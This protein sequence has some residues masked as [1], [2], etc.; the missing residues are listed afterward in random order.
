L[1]NKLKLVFKSV[2][3]FVSPAE[4]TSLSFLQL[5]DSIL[6]DM[7]NIYAFILCF[8]T[9]IGLNPSD[10]IE[11]TG[12]NTVAVETSNGKL[13]GKRSGD[14]ISFLG[15]P[16]AEPP[17]GKYR[18]R[19][20][21]PKKA[22]YPAE[23]KAFNYSAECLQSALYAGPS[24]R[25]D[26]DC[27]YLNVWLPAKPRNVEPLP[28]LVWIYGGAFLHGSA[29]RPEYAGHKLASKGSVIVVSLNYRVG[30]LGFLVS[31]RDSLFGN[32]GLHD[33][34]LALQWIV[35]NIHLFGGDPN[36]ITVFGESAGAMSI[37]L[38][39]FDQ[40]YNF[41]SQGLAQKSKP[42][43]HGVILQSNP[44]GYKYRSLAVANFIGNA[45]KELLDCED[46]R[47]LHAESADELIHVQDT[48][49]AVP[50]S[51]GDFFT[52]G[53][54]VTD[55]LYYREVRL[56]HGPSSNITVRQP[57]ETMN[58]LRK[59]N[60]PILM[61]TNSHEGIVFVYTA[62]PRRMIK[63]L[64]QAVVWSFFRESAI[65][66]LRM[67]API[68]RRIDK[69]LYP[70]YRLVLSQII[71]DYLFRCPNLLFSSQA[72]K[73]GTPV[74]LYEFSLPTRT[75]GFDC[76]DGLA[77]HTCELPYPFANIE[78]IYSEYSYLEANG[79]TRRSTPTRMANESGASSNSLVMQTNPM[80]LMMSSMRTWIGFG[81]NNAADKRQKRFK[82]DYQIAHL[83]SDYW[84]TFATYGNPN[85]LLDLNGV[86]TGTRPNNAPWWPRLFGELPSEKALFEM[87]R[88]FTRRMKAARV[89][90]ERMRR[91]VMPA[92]TGGGGGTGG[93]SGDESSVTV[94]ESESSVT[95]SMTV[96]TMNQEGS[97]S[98]DY[99]MLAWDESYRTAIDENLDYPSSLATYEEDFLEDYASVS[100]DDDEEINNRKQRP[101]DDSLS[102]NLGRRRRLLG[103]DMESILQ[104]TTSTYADYHEKYRYLHLMKF[105]METGVS[106]YENEDCI[107]SNWN[108]LEYKF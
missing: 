70:D 41:R 35:D 31:I 47:C 81:F 42:L 101:P 72:A 102:I 21:A 28:V 14:V 33:Q 61:G 94:V 39:M 57:M 107:C 99:T 1:Q 55:N 48:L 8:L 34:K 60:V 27:L 16:Y 13:V 98:A 18:F 56:R 87:Q 84:S 25:S 68:T 50:R 29:S 11:I 105:S 65:R 104:R 12:K 69:S 26:E 5:Y 52:W 37:V 15:I 58:E 62:W 46:L 108:K 40:Y 36:R 90:R 73:L 92:A 30:A 63:P 71:G 100:Y 88:D 97:L 96:I 82:L 22:W 44:L 83:M 10:G 85:G 74:F 49:M 7:I 103:S 20:S 66:V 53:P 38:H 4:M 43:F 95:T 77:C 93:E 19:P 45:Y 59:L 106:I 2:A 91:S 78:L 80:D 3:M 89:E 64:Y 23:W 75:P 6:R 9:W 67:Y 17:I 79:Y 76:C 51:M 32:Y 86:T 54:V 24:T